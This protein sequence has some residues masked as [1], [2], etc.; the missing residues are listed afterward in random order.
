[1]SA[2]PVRLSWR[3]QQYLRACGGCSH[4][5]ALPRC[6]C[7]CACDFHEVHWSD[8]CSQQ[9]SKPAMPSGRR[10][11]HCSFSDPPPVSSGRPYALVERSLEHWT[12]HHSGEAVPRGLLRDLLAESVSASAVGCGWVSELGARSMQAGGS[13]LCSS[14]TCTCGTCW[15]NNICQMQGPRLHYIIMEEPL[16]FTSTCSC[17]CTR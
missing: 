14:R 5:L 12:A 2:C 6:W 10:Y 8:C 16:F 13:W 1:M 4:D 17:R 3:L 9:L 15:P 7:G 11:V